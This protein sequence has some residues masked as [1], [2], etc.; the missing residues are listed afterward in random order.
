MLNKYKERLIVMCSDL[1][2]CTYETYCMIIIA[3]YQFIKA[4]AILDNGGSDDSSCVTHYI[5]QH[6]NGIPGCVSKL[7]MLYNLIC[8]G[9]Y[10]GECSKSLNEFVNGHDLIKILREFRIRYS[11]D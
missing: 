6:H 10:T 11:R 2:N 5:A 4:K 7:I 9:C 3:L 8:V 1:S